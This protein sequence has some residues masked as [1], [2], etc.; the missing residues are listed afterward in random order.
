MVEERH[1]VI[2][3]LAVAEAATLGMAAEPLTL[4]EQTPV[5]VIGRLERKLLTPALAGGITP[6]PGT[7]FDAV[8]PAPGVS[9]PDGEGGATDSGSR[10]PGGRPMPCS[11]VRNS[12]R[13]VPRW[14]TRPPETAAPVNCQVAQPQR[15]HM[16]TSRRPV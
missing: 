14:S 7:G 9:V 5:R 6:S 8:S 16:P 1:D 11:P 2:C 10:S 13:R 4:T 12:R 3:R 15:P